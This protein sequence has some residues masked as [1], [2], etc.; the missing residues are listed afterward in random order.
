MG[1]T[2]VLHG[3]WRGKPTGIGG[4]LRVGTANPQRV[5]P[6]MT[7]PLHT[8]GMQGAQSGRRLGQ[9][10]SQVERQVLEAS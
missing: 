2:H 8:G 1:G 6:T 5:A 4:S 9:V 10:G 7:E 3:V